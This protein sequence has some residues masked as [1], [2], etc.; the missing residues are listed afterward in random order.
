MPGDHVDRH[1][2]ADQRTSARRPV[3]VDVEPD[4][5]C[6]S[7]EPSRRRSAPRTKA[8]IPVDLYGGFPDLVALEA[9]CDRARHRR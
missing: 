4:T 5:W 1:R 3:F 8:I 2:G 6:L 9:L 7:V